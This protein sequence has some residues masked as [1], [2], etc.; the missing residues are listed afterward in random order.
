[1]KRGFLPALLIRGLIVATLIVIPAA[2]V[3]G[4]PDKTDLSLKLL[5]LAFVVIAIALLV[6]RFQKNTPEAGLAAQFNIENVE[7]FTLGHPYIRAAGPRQCVLR[8][9]REQDSRP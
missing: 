6:R 4:P 1:M 7:S 2:L 9:L 5:L 3:L 8:Y